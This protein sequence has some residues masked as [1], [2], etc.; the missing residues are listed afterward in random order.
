VGDRIGK[1]DA[2]DLAYNAL[3]RIE[4]GRDI[5]GCVSD[6]FR[7][8]ARQCLSNCDPVR[9]LRA[10]RTGTNAKVQGIVHIERIRIVADEMILC[11]SPSVPVRS[12][13]VPVCPQEA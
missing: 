8:G 4:I 1:A 13:S 2:G 11:I 9:C 10:V 5:G 3:E 7:A 6:G 12:I